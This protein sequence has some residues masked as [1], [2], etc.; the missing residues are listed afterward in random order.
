MPDLTRAQ[1]NDSLA[2][3]RT[4]TN[5][6]PSVDIFPLDSRIHRI[7]ALSQAL[8]IA[9]CRK[10]YNRAATELFIVRRGALADRP[11]IAQNWRTGEEHSFSSIAALKQFLSPT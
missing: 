3:Y 1:Y 9:G 10:V 4:S 5:A 11:Y 7:S 6:H 8:L 2:R